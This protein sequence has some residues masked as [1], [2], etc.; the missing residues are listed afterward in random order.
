MISCIRRLAA[1][2][3]ASFGAAETGNTLPSN[4]DDPTSGSTDRE[5]RCQKNLAIRAWVSF[6]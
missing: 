1:S 6:H 4:G 2:A 5:L 3:S